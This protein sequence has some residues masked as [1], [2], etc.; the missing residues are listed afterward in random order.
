MDKSLQRMTRSEPDVRLM[1]ATDLPSV[2]AIQDACYMEQFRESRTSLYAK[3]LASPSTCFVASLA[4][5]SVGYL[6]ALPGESSNPPAWNAATC[7]LPGSPDCLYLHDLA[8]L[9]GARRT[10]AGRALVGEFMNRLRASSTGRACLIAVQ[11]SMSYWARHGFRPVPLSGALK[12]RLST[13]GD[14]VVYMERAA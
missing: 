4:G 7:H 8:V 10:G 6:F 2:L 13:Y 5:D 9:P 12:A 11:N 3:L 1:S 14:Q